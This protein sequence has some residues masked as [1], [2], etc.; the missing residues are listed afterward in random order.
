M[1][2][3]RLLTL[4]ACVL[5]V[6]SVANAGTEG[7]ALSQCG[8]V[9]S[10]RA[11]LAQ[12]LDCSD[13]TGD[14]VVGLLGRTT[15]DLNGF[16]IIGKAPG[17]DVSVPF[18]TE[19]ELIWCL[20]NCTVVGPGTLQSGLYGIHAG[21][22]SGWPV[23]GAVG[24]VAV[25]DVS[26]SD[27]VVGIF[28]DRLRRGS[29]GNPRLGKV[30]ADRLDMSGNKTAIRSGSI[31]MNESTVADG[32]IG[33]QAVHSVRVGSSSVTGNSAYGVTAR[34]VHAVASDFTANGIDLITRN[35]PRLDAATVCDHSAVNLQ[36]DTWGVCRLD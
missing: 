20:K 11:Y 33:L 16:S 19:L 30:R 8:E 28:S 15:L 17:S 27:T 2:H 29:N 5:L 13:Y 21:A 35:R 1:F 25:S 3:C 36:G 6:G 9:A 23:R 31:R 26:I 14:F 22:R 34:K 12:D 32:T 7:R 4:T 10:G 24:K 18:G